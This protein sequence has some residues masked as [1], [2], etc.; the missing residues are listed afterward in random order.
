MDGLTPNL[1]RSAG[2]ALPYAYQHAGE[3]LAMRISDAHHLPGP[4]E[5]LTLTHRLHACADAFDAM[6]DAADATRADA[7]LAQMD[8][9]LR[10]LEGVAG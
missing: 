8:E 1:G 9:L 10:A 2:N 6:G 7:I 4:A 5:E 3:R